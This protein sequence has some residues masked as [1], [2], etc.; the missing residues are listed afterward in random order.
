M[1]KIAYRLRQGRVAKL[2]KDKETLQVDLAKAL[3]R[4]DVLT[5]GQAASSQVDEAQLRPLQTE[6]EALK[7]EVTN[8]DGQIILLRSQLEIADRKLRLSDMENAMLKSE[9]ELRKRSSSSQS[10]DDGGRVSVAL[11]LLEPYI[12]SV[13][14]TNVGSEYMPQEFSFLTDRQSITVVVARS[15]LGVIQEENVVFVLDVSG[16]M[17]VY[18]EDVKSAVNLALVQQ[19][20][21]T[22][23]HFNMVTFTEIQMEFHDDLV[24]ATPRNLEDAMRFCQHTQ[25][26]RITSDVNSCIVWCTCCRQVAEAIWLLPYGMPGDLVA[27]KFKKAE[28]ILVITDGKTEVSEDLLT[29]VKVHY[30]GHPRR[31]KIHAVGINCVPG[32]TKQRALQSL[33]HLT[34]GSFRSV[35]LE[36]DTFVPVALGQKVKG[37]DLFDQQYVTTDEDTITDAVIEDPSEDD[38]QQNR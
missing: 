17:Q 21:Q 28:A 30:L 14:P 19:F 32:R 2:E 5:A 15:V 24:P 20:H 1:R 11:A 26:G 33:A 13:Q 38:R 31:P 37:I 6:C 34:Q 10:S 12:F 29:Q 25:E 35:C 9:M 18:L 8:K 4:V 22:Q 36:Q 27:F 23:R 16:S 7:D 3:A